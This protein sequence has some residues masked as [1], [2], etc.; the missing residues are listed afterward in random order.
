MW[1]SLTSQI[2]NLLSL[3]RHRDISSYLIEL[4]LQVVCDKTSLMP[5]A[6]Y[7][8]LSTKLPWGDQSCLQNAVIH[9]M[10]LP[11]R[12]FPSS[13][14]SSHSSLLYLFLT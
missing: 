6:M 7:C 11:E 10:P 1:S 12:T 13:L 4:V 2:S 3:L 8:V 14:F 5:F 9:F